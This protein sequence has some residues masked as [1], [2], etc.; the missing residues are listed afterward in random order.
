[1]KF[2]YLV[3][4]ITLYNFLKFHQISYSGLFF[5]KG[6]KSWY[7]AWSGSDHF[8]IRIRTFL[9]YRSGYY[10]TSGYGSKQNSRLRVRHDTEIR[11]RDPPTWLTPRLLRLFLRPA[12]CRVIALL[13][14]NIQPKVKREEVCRSLMQKFLTQMC[15]LEKLIGFDTLTD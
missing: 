7:R 9:K 5:I 14:T 3:Q 2:R 10:Q 4:L 8:K 6:K 13:T 12:C 11:I 15:F 1:M